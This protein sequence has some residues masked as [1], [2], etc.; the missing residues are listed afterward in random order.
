[1]R[2]PMIYITLANHVGVSMGSCFR[3]LKNTTST[4]YKDHRMHIYIIYSNVS[5][6]TT[7]YGRI[8]VG[9]SLA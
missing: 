8:E 2:I 1:M 7:H 9:S 3:V 6:L 5:R 4:S